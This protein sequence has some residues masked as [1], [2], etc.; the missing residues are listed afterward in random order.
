MRRAHLRLGAAAAVAILAALAAT[1]AAS[2]DGGDAA[3][4]FEP[5]FGVRTSAP[6]MIEPAAP[7]VRTRPIITVGET[8]DDGYRFE[9]IPDGIAIHRRPFQFLSVD[10]YVNHET[11]AVP[12]PVFPPTTFFDYTNAR[13]RS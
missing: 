10:V 13:S 1:S 5:L 2:A 3:G 6:S 7:G 8:L 11:S 12:F 4:I 9:S